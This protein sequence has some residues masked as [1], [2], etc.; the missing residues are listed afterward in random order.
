M[1]K[2][3]F[4]DFYG[5]VVAEISPIAQQ[6]IMDVY[7]NSKAPSPQEVTRYWYKTFAE[8]TLIYNGPSFKSQH[9]MSLEI[10]KDLVRDFQCACEPQELLARMEEHWRTSPI[11][12]DAA[13]FL[14]ELQLPVYFV[15]NCDDS[16]VEAEIERYG[17]HPAGVITSEEARYSKPHRELFLYALKKVGLKPEE[18][19]QVG[20]SLEGDV[21]VPASLGIRS[22]WLNREKKEAPEGVESVT[23]LRDLKKCLEQERQ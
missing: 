23:D 15:T 3:L 20:D 10:F 12:E 8:K 11:Y 17:L 5:T 14:K 22:V 2:A 13:E 7:K 16:Y 18:V 1:I 19:M 21:K 9:D 4:M 6:V